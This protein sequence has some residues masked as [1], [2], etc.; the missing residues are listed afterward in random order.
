MNPG[1]TISN[2]RQSGEKVQLNRGGLLNLPTPRFSVE[3]D[4]PMVLADRTTTRRTA[5]A[6]L[7]AVA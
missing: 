2:D 5:T 6:T 4:T 3:R 1:S 7:H